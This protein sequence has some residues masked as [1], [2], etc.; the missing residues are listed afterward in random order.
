MTEN[1]A[2]KDEI[3]EMF[4]ITKK[5]GKKGAYP[6]KTLI[7][8]KANFASSET[9]SKHSSDP[10]Q[11]LTERMQETS[12]KDSSDSS[13]PSDSIDLSNNSDEKVPGKFKGTF[14]NKDGHAES[15]CLQQL[16]D[17]GSKA[18][19]I[20][21][22]LIQS[23]APCH[24]CADKIIK[25]KKEME[26][27]GK[28]VSIKVEFANYYYWIGEKKTNEYGWKNLD[29]LRKM[30]EKG[31]DLQ[32]IQ[33]KESWETLFGDHELVDLTEEDKNQLREKAD[34]DERKERENID[35]N[36]REEKKLF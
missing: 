10:L 24:E 3:S 6:H 13:D 15:R 26:E 30:A 7:F 23:Y 35:R 20:D 27:E 11:V 12:L 31:I 1:R 17:M 25:Y 22:E 21:V 33:G 18:K 32:L 16:K 28:E 36:L 5:Y 9:V 29:G 2:K 34:S 19:K 14:R 8:C 4:I